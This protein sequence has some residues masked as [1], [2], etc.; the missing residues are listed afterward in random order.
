MFMPLNWAW[1]GDPVDLVDEL[2]DLDLD[3]H[4]VLVGVDAVRR[5]YGQLADAVQDVLRFL[6][7]SPSVVWMNEIPFS[8][9]AAGLVAGRESGE[10]SFSETASPEASSPAAVDPLPGD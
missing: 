6:R 7:G 2:G 5:L 8:M 9:F 4:A 1:R 10:R 3:L